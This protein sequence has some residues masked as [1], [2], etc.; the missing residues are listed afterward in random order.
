MKYIVY[1]QPKCNYCT[2]AEN[3]LNSNKL[4]Y[5][6]V[7]ILKDNEAYKFITEEENLYTVPQV[8]TEDALGVTEYIGGY[9]ALAEHL[10]K[11]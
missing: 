4:P 8:F 6:Y 1:G 3:L 10:K 9:E 7:N 2:R 11:T 5:T